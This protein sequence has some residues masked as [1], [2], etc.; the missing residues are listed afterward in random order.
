MATSSATI[1][2]RFD[3]V[4]EQQLVSGVT[5]PKATAIDEYNETKC[6]WI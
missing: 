6:I 5:L 2:R 4:A 1:I 3:Q